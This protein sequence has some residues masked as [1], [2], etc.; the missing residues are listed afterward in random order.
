LK[1][2]IQ[3]QENKSPGLLQISLGKFG[4][5]ELTPARW[6]T[7]GHLGRRCGTAAFVDIGGWSV[8][9]GLTR[10]AACRGERVGRPK[11]A[12]LDYYAWASIPTRSRAFKLTIPAS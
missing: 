4:R 3:Y 6:A 5:N 10:A 2:C 7:V 12:G 8:Q 9:Q 1:V 11:L